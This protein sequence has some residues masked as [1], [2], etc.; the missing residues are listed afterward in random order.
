MAPLE[1][2]EVGGPREDL[3]VQPERLGLRRARW[4]FS[5]IAFL[6]FGKGYEGAKDDF[7]Y[8]YSQDDRAHGK[9]KEMITSSV[10]LFRTPRD[11]VQ[12]RASYEF[13]AGF[14]ADGNPTWT[15]EIGKRKAVFADPNGVGWG[16]RVTYHPG[17]RRYFLT[18]FHDDAG[19]WGLFDAAEPW[20]PWTTVGYWEKWIDPVF[21][22]GFTFNQKWME[23][24]GKTAWMVFSGIER[25]DSFNVIKATF[26]PRSR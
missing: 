23:D 14:D 8:A 9:G 12:D 20:G 5:D 11:K 18:A 3:A 21:K 2:R 25:Y 10:A 4:G 7:E 15:R 19:G 17:F 22:F 16:V 24:G 26:E 13:F 1:D 6:S